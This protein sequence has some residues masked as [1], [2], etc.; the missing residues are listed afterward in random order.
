M[1]CVFG[2]ADKIIGRPQY[3]VFA[4]F[5]SFAL[6]GLMEFG[7]PMAN[8]VRSQVAVALSGGVMVFIG[9]TVSRDPWLGAAV[10]AAG[11]F[12]VL[13]A[14]VISSQIA[15]ASNAVILPL[16]LATAF[17]GSVADIP[18]RLAG[19]GTAALVSLVAITV[20]WPLPAVDPLRRPTVAVSRSLA[21]RLRR[22]PGAGD[23]A[24]ASDEAAVA[25]LG[26]AFL[27]MPF[28]PTGL[29]TQTRLTVRLVEELEWLDRAIARWHDP[30]E[31]ASD[32]AAADVLDACAEALDQDASGSRL[33]AAIATLR[34]QRSRSEQAALDAAEADQQGSVTAPEFV[35]R[36]EPSFRAQEL[37]F[38]VGGVGQTVMATLAAEG[39]SWW[40]ALLG[41]EVGASE[42][43]VTASLRARAHLNRNSV[44]LRNSV[45]GAVGL[46]L[47]T[48]IAAEV[49]VQHSFWVVLGALTVLRSNA[50]ST[51]QVVTRAVAGTLAGFVVGAVI[52]SLVGSSTGILWAILPLSIL[53]GGL[54]PA[55]VSFA[56]GQAAFTVTILSLF[57]IIAPEGWRIGVVRVEDVLLGCGVSLVVSLILWPRGAAAQLATAIG[58]AYA[59]AGQYLSEA[60]DFASA[61]C[62]S[63]GAPPVPPT[64][65]ADRANA[66]ARRLDDAFRTY[67]A[68]RGAKPAPL[69]DITNLLIGSAVL[70]LTAD[71]VLALWHRSPLHAPVATTQARSE[72]V[73]KASRV[74]SWYDELAQSLVT[75]ADINEPLVAQ[76]DGRADF[77]DAL[78]E[79]L[80]SRDGRTA[81]TVRLVWTD[82]HVNVAIDLQ[83]T[84]G[85][86]A[87]V[88]AGGPR[89][90]GR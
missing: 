88:V 33:A 79:D 35:A 8:R 36:L 49:G 3:T 19:F 57:T 14:G 31:N 86:S 27:A 29:N 45:R 82:F 41:H 44:W 1:P 34:T 10:M 22:V 21:A 84:I 69:S 25:T 46:G 73:A 9:T 60:V 17:P 5:G 63:R 77:L 80:A 4:A 24:S 72:L 2:F 15:R 61:C 48:L 87:S 28:R 42:Q 83:R 47:A 11:S 12:I 50:L 37:A 89:P 70:R 74:R 53:I 68:E 39:R 38:A 43:L 66:A 55:I 64:H 71:A 32:E 67:L 6:I 54:A 18:A 56:T 85:E 78:G 30:T 13:F 7:G 59:L 51:G 16:V 90:P 58:D 52:I 20:L 76:A 75:H 81:T 65:H 26:R 62:G 40:A 23:G